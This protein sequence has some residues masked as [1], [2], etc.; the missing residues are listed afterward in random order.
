MILD[1]NIQLEN[2]FLENF[3]PLKKYVEYCE[4]KTKLWAEVLS[5][6]VKFLSVS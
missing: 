3:R 2:T 5:R 4:P 6:P 1:W